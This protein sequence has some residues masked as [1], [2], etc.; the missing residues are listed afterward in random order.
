MKKEDK[1]NTLN[2][3]KS[4]LSLLESNKLNSKESTI[5]FAGFF[6]SLILNKKVF[7]NNKDI[8]AF[9]DSVYLKPLKLSPFKSYLYRSRTLLGSRVSR[10]ILE[11]ATYSN[12]IELRKLTMDYL[13]NQLGKNKNKEDKK[14][15]KTMSNLMDELS[16]W[17]K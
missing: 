6:Y 1:I 4:Q 11:K 7:K 14:T 17:L 13:D 2:N 16:G 9:L 3:F 5:Y 10:Y 15:K 12:I 8:N